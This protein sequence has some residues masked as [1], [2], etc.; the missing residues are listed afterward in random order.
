[1]LKPKQTQKVG[2]GDQRISAF[3]LAELAKRI[4]IP[5][6][7]LR[8]QVACGAIACDQQPPGR[9]QPWAPMISRD[10][11]V[12]FCVSIGLDPMRLMQ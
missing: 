6:K 9:Q 2:V 8:V 5:E 10:A 11:A 4:A 1:M 7:V 12:E 3:S